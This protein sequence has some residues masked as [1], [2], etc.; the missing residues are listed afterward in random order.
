MRVK[1]LVADDDVDNRTIAREILE[2]SGFHVVMA[3]DGEEALAVIRA[4][5]PAVVVLDLSMP[6]LSGWE[7]AKR[8]RADDAIKSTP[9]IAFTAHAL[10]GDELKAKTA[11]CD[12][13]ISKPCKPRDLV[14][15]VKQWIDREYDRQ[16]KPL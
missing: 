1:V 13:Y 11:G 2:A 7:V 8:V 9:L 15:K 5:R 12:D 4:E 16:E 3:V 6:K 10:V 14:T